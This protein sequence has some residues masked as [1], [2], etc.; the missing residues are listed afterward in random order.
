MDGH[1]REAEQQ[2]FEARCWRTLR[3]AVRP[4]DGLARLGVQMTDEEVLEAAL[5]L[6]RAAA[7]RDAA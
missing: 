2:F 5:R 1:D 4:L 3:D 7:A 6:V